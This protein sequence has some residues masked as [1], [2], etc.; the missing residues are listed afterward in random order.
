M[1][2]QQD[3]FLQLMAAQFSSAH[4]SNILF[5]P[6]MWNQTCPPQQMNQST[7]FVPNE[8]ISVEIDDTQNINAKHEDVRANI[9]YD[10][11]CHVKTDSDENETECSD[12]NIWYSTDEND[13]DRE[14]PT[15]YDSGMWV[16]HA[17]F[18]DHNEARP[19]DKPIKACLFR[20]FMGMRQIMN[21]LK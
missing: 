2:V 17:S 21:L 15:C 3:S 9:E 8:D 1:F 6:N 14:G 19:I 11:N 12:E 10:H 16:G 4:G 18:D 7:S 20:N 13:D 5:Q